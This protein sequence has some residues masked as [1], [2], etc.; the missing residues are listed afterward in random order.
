MGYG[1]WAM[2]Y[3]LWAM[4]YGLYEILAFSSSRARREPALSPSHEPRVN[5]ANGLR[6]RRTREF[7]RHSQ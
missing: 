1:L 4:G 2:G 3:G 5:S 7:I 6:M